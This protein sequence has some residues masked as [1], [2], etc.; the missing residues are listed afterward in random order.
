M[1][2]F[3]PTGGDPAS[4]PGPV[5]STP[6]PVQPAGYPM[7][8]AIVDRKVDVIREPVLS[9]EGDNVVVNGRSLTAKG[10]TRLQ[11]ERMGFL[12][13]M[14]VPLAG[15]LVFVLSG[16]SDSARWGT[17]YG[18]APVV[19]VATVGLLV[20]VIGA[21]ILLRFRV[22]R[23]WATSSEPFRLSTPV[24]AVR[25][26]TRYPTTWGVMLI[27]FFCLWGTVIG[28]VF[29][30]ALIVANLV[31]GKNQVHLWMASSKYR[32]QAQN[33]A[34]AAEIADAI[35]AGQASAAPVSPLPAVAGPPAPT[36]PPPPA[37]PAAPGPA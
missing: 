12:A 34:Q 9:V 1:S 30:I 37:P 28:G 36:V 5:V 27:L 14:L 25:V 4:Q 19:L 33:R 20:L 31:Y 8:T 7:K 6:P 13:L 21:S 16:L 22:N 35:R 24:S 32:F 15:F 23:Y 10:A 3:E 18:N 2:D 29:W 11:W 26:Q 17:P